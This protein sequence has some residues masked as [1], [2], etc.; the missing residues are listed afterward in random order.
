MQPHAYAALVL[1]Q[2]VTSFLRFSHSVIGLTW[3][4]EIWKRRQNTFV[5]MLFIFEQPSLDF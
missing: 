5:L 2:F 3:C 4:L 1:M